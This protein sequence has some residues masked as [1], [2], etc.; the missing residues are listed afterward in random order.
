MVEKQQKRNKI[1]EFAY[2]YYTPKLKHNF[3][4]DYKIMKYLKGSMN[5]FIRNKKVNLRLILNYIVTLSNL[6]H[7]KALT[8]I[9]YHEIQKELW[10]ILTTFLYFLNII[11]DE[12]NLKFVRIKTKNVIDYNLLEKLNQL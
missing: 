10:P 9:L 7:P 5:K 2:I 3:E 1:Q 12:V 6:F 11:G 4:E 8:V